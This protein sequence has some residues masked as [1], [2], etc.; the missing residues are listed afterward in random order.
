[1]ALESMFV[2]RNQHSFLMGIPYALAFLC[3]W[4][5]FRFFMSKVFS[6]PYKLG[7]TVRFKKK[8]TKKKKNCFLLSVSPFHANV[9]VALESW[10]SMFVWR[11]QH[12]FLMGIPYTLGFL[13]RWVEVSVFFFCP[14]SLVSL[15]ISWA[16]PSD[17]F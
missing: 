1:M 8:K 9:G 7:R 6:L 10:P 4:V 13:C 3:R 15:N 16:E 2:W 11:N 12:S 14:K 17:F 5:K